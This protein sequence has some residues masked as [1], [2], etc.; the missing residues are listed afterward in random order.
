MPAFVQTLATAVADDEFRLA[1]MAIAAVPCEAPVAM[2][3]W[4]QT[5]ERFFFFR[6]RPGR[7]AMV[8]HDLCWS[9]AMVAM[10]NF[11]A[12]TSKSL[13]K[14]IYAYMMYMSIWVYDVYAIVKGVRHH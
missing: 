5:E 6:C 12:V 10:S 1:K 11:W 2:K 3:N 7:P 4:R 13:H 9:M 14:S 8:I